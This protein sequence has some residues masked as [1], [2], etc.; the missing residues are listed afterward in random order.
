MTY[1]LAT[2]MVFEILFA[3]AFSGVVKNLIK[4]M[5]LGSRKPVLLEDNSH[6]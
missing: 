4:P 6:P 5:K 1:Y 3:N 2:G